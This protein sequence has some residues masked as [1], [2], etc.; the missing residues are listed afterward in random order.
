MSPR[1]LLLLPVLL[2][3]TSCTGAIEEPGDREAGNL[4]GIG[5]PAIGGRGPGAKPGSTSEAG[6]NGA[7][8]RPPAGT[9]R[10]PI[11]SQ[12]SASSRFVRLNH[13]SGKTPCAMCCGSTSPLGLSSAFVAEPLRGTFDTNGSILSVSARSLRDYQ[14]A[15]ETL[16]GKVASDP[17]LLAAI[18]PARRAREPG[19]RPSSR[20]SV[21]APSGARSRAARSRACMACSTRGPTLIGSG[22]A[23][24]D[25]VELVL[26]YLFQSPHF[27]YRT[28]LS[29]AV[30]DGKIPLER[31]E[32]ASRLS[33]ALTNTHARRR[34]VRRRRRATS[35]ATRD[36]VL[37][38]GRAL[39][40]HAGRAA[41]RSPT[42]TTSCCDMREYEDRRERRRRRFRSSPTAWPRT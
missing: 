31:Y 5:A 22:D 26:S 15:A 18:A 11:I 20:A 39:A 29:S 9:F 10:G 2:L 17:E 19:A 4:S 35:S 28:E 27:I 12:P 42:S 21:C 6:A 13:R 24:A 30:V 33:Y 32:V 16:A 36:G 3:A 14:S 34:P 7:V 41:A 40:G 23:F 8:P 1:Q 37:R 25:G 38:A